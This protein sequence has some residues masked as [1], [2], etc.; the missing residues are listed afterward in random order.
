MTIVQNHWRYIRLYSCDQ[1]T[2]VLEVIRNERLPIRHARRLSNGEVSILIVHGEVN[3]VTQ[4]SIPT[5]KTKKKSRPYCM[6]NV[7]DDIIIALA[8]GNESCV[9]WSGNM[10]PVDQMIACQTSKGINRPSGYL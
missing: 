9:D 3:T 1:H 4:K 8:V 5:R 2:A 10:V 7:Y 6:G